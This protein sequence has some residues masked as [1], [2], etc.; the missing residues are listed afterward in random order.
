MYDPY[1]FFTSTCFNL[2]MKIIHIC[3]QK[4][5]E[6]LRLYN[7]PKTTFVVEFKGG[8][9]SDNV[10]LIEECLQLHRQ[11]HVDIFKNSLE[12]FVILVRKR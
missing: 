10:C 11:K 2:R 7:F 4:D 1:D 9:D 8:R 5:V 3:S 12:K 6:L